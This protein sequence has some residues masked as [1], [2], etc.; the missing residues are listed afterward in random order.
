M[1][2]SHYSILAAVSFAIFATL[3]SVADR[4]L[5]CYYENC[6]TF[7]YNR[8]FLST[9]LSSPTGIFELVMRFSGQFFITP[10]IGVGVLSALLSG[11]AVLGVK[12]VEKWAGRF[13]VAGTLPAVVVG[14]L[15]FYRNRMFA[16]LPMLAVVEALL[17]IIPHKRHIGVEAPGTGRKWSVILQLALFALTVGICAPL[18]IKGQNEFL[19]KQS[20]MAREGQWEKMVSA[21]EK[22]RY[23]RIPVFQNYANLALAQKGQLSKKIFKA[24]DGGSECLFPSPDRS[25]ETGTMLADIYLSIGQVAAAQRHAF[26]ANESYR[27]YSPRLLQ[28]LV[29][30]NI[31]LGNEAVAMKYIDLLKQTL[32][33]RLWAKKYET[34]CN[35]TRTTQ[36]MK[37]LRKCATVPNYFTQYF[38]ADVEIADIL[39][40]C[41][42][43]RVA[44]QYLTALQYIFSDSA[45]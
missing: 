19:K 41:P 24:K 28:T 25:P 29:K 30:T 32:F 42:E 17:L 18:C 16:A 11:V 22:S 8:E 33:Y 44:Q 4:F 21:M 37:M 2:I 9:I 7:F 26:E 43:N 36:E 40:V 5:P 45:Q 6:G 12:V 27:G 31:V 35:G 34:I 13:M 23:Y 39:C 10:L 1:K 14:M 20:C 15:L 38:R 3:I